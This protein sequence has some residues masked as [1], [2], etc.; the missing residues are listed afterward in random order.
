MSP[1]RQGFFRDY[2]EKMLNWNKMFM[3]S[4]ASVVS[5]HLNLSSAQTPNEWWVKSKAQTYRKGVNND[6]V[7]DKNSSRNRFWT[8][9]VYS[10]W[11]LVLLCF[12]L[13]LS[14]YT[15]SVENNNK[16]SSEKGFISFD[17]HST[18]S[19]VAAFY[20]SVSFFVFFFLMEIS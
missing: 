1:W 6:D 18:D 5:G 16:V 12:A 14:I 20:C 4:F 8:I 2:E 10:L 15:I 3:F 19:V 7:A 9:S 17:C 13:A 11:H